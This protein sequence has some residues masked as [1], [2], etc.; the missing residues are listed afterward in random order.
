MGAVLGGQGVVPV[1]DPVAHEALLLPAAL[2]LLLPVTHEL[3]LWTGCAA[4][5][6]GVGGGPGG[7][8]SG[9]GLVGG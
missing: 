5:S 1:P 7:M 9:M 4:A 8:G 2:H 6:A 3:E